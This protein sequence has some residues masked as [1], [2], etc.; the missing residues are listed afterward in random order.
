MLLD[1]RTKLYCVA[2]S[3][4]QSQYERIIAMPAYQEVAKFCQFHTYEEVESSYANRTP[5][6]HL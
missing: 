6:L 1:F 3:E 5:H 4:R 2:E